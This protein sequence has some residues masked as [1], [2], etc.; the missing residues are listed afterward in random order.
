MSLQN[1]DV[2]RT[3]SAWASLAG[4]VFVPHNEQEYRKLVALLDGL[5]DEVGENEAHPLASLM[6]IVGVLVEAYE[7]E[8]VP[9]LITE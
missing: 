7:S 4:T 3:T 8:H 6:E 2:N 9:E 5:V 1:L